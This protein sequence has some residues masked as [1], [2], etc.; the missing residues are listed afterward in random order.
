MKLFDSCAHPKRIHGCLIEAP[1]HGVFIGEICQI[2]RSLCQPEVIARAVVVGFR[3][4]QT[5]L[6]LIGRSQG[7][8]REVVIRPDGQPFVFEMGEHLAGKIFNAAGEEIGVL[9]HQTTEFQ[10]HQAVLRRVDSP[11]A[12]VSQRS[13]V[14]EPLTTGVNA[15]DGLLTCGKGQRMGIFSAAG[16][17]KTSLM[18]M[19]MNHAKADICVIAL[20]GERGREVTEFIH[21]LRASP[22]SSQTILVYSTSDSSAVERCNAALLATAMAMAMAMA[23]YFRDLGRDVLL[24]V[25]SMTRCA[26]WRWPPVNCLPDVD[27]PLPFLNNCHNY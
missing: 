25:D 5:L 24:F 21:E 18:S 8:T 11:A 2:E 1:L 17:G 6:S 20:I 19:I 15:I 22:R 3:E 4:G 27:I 14:C 13:P 23:E 7:L 10:P 16:S 26:M 12:S 9:T